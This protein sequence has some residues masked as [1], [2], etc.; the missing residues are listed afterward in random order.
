MRPQKHMPAVGLPTDVRRTPIFSASAS[1][2]AA[3]GA[4]GGSETLW[5]V[6]AEGG[7]A[8]VGAAVRRGGLIG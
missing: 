4:A 5:G 3:A 8:G 7:S 6:W 1:A 2:P